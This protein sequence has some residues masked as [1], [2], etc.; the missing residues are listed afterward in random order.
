MDSNKTF[1][2]G[3]ASWDMRSHPKI[4]SEGHYF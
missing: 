3:Q 2:K 4:C 1:K